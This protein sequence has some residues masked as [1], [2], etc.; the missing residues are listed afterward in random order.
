MNVVGAWSGS[1]GLCA[2]GWCALS[3]AGFT[4]LWEVRAATA[5]RSSGGWSW[6]WIWIWSASLCW[7]LWLGLRSLLKT[8][9]AV[10][11]RRGAS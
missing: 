3:L 5:F 6:I 9:P 7:S 2:P 10:L 4:G 11:S 1:N 8:F